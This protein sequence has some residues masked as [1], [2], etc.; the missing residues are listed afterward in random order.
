MTVGMALSSKNKNGVDYVTEQGFMVI[1]TNDVVAAFSLVGNVLG[2]I[3][4]FIGIVLA[5]TDRWSPI[6]I[7]LWVFFALIPLWFLG[8]AVAAMSELFGAL[9]NPPSLYAAQLAFDILSSFFLILSSVS[10]IQ[11]LEV[12]LHK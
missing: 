6:A 8:G 1:Y 11:T 5:A 2:I 9:T 4:V 12:R 3:I 10:L 7:A